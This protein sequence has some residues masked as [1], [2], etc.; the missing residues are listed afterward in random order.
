MEMLKFE[1]ITQHAASSQRDANT[2]LTDLFHRTKTE[3]LIAN[4]SYYM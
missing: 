4:W 1:L 3:Q 2:Y